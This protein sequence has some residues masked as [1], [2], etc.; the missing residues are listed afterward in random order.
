MV[1][2]RGV[3]V[4]LLFISRGTNAMDVRAA[5]WDFIKINRDLVT[6]EEDGIQK[7]LDVT[8][9]RD[10]LEKSL[11][12]DLF[13]RTLVPPV[14]IQGWMLGCDI[15]TWILACYEGNLEGMKDLRWLSLKDRTPEGP[16]LVSLCLLALLIRTIRMGS[17]GTLQILCKIPEIQPIVRV[18][19]SYLLETLRPKNVCLV[20]YLNNL[21]DQ[22][23]SHVKPVPDLAI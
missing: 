16:H 19:R 21:A 7:I 2:V 4:A 3:L 6:Y 8:V 5:E 9:T 18:A 15:K 22:D 23:D 12:K 14:D 17:L 20:D 11:L 1:Y 13:N 10:D